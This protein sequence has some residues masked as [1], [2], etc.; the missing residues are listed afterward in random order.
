MP[1]I[2]T[3]KKRRMSRSGRAAIVTAARNRL[4]KNRGKEA[5]ASNKPTP[6]RP[7]TVSAAVKAKL[8]ASRPRRPT[9]SQPQMYLFLD[10]ETTGVTPQDRMVSICWALYDSDGEE[11]MIKH[12]IIYPEE[13][14]IPDHAVEIHGI[15]TE[16]ARQRG[17]PLKDALTQLHD[18]IE[19]HEPTHCIGHNVSFDIRIV[20]REYADTSVRENI[21]PLPIFCTMRQTIHICR[22][23]RSSGSRFKPP[24]LEELHK[25]LFGDSHGDAHD[26][27]ADVKACAKC[28][29]RLL[30][31]RSISI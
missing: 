19:E 18:D 17:I 15:T 16:I 12:H 22:I 21:S 28:F 29:F 25:H 3:K 10:T 23:P 4:T 5:Q 20:K 13:F 26:A 6:A 30:E 31:L 14:D 7:K 11:L 1:M 27:K 2:T 24:K 8:V 9:L